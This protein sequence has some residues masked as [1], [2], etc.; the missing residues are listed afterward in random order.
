MPLASLITL[1]LFG[2]APP[3]GSIHVVHICAVGGV[4]RI[5]V[6]DAQRVIW[7]LQN[8]HLK[9]EDD[10]KQNRR[11]ELQQNFQ[12]LIISEI[13]QT[14]PC[15]AQAHRCRHACRTKNILGRQACAYP[16]SCGLKYSE[17]LR[18]TRHP[19]RRY[20]PCRAACFRQTRIRS[21]RSAAWLPHAGDPPMNRPRNL[22]DTE[23]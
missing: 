22:A 12:L 4:L 17:I 14:F 15:R 11:Y 20:L 21:C 23:N 6:E 5:A 7:T 2:S 16:Y 9:N 3:D 13:K 19:D 10:K 1:K 8:Q 18:H